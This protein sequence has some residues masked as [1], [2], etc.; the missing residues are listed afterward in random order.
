MQHK[1]ELSGVNTAKLK[2]LKSDETHEHRML[3]K[4]GDSIGRHAKPRWQLR[5]NGQIVL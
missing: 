5:Y 4:S 2:V 3:K 1:V